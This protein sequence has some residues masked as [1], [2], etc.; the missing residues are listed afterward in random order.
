MAHTQAEPRL[1]SD[2][3]YAGLEPTPGDTIV[4]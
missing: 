2:V 3:P 4:S 1:A